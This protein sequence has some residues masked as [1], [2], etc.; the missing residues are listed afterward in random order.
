MLL[1]GTLFKLFD[2]HINRRR[3]R[4]IMGAARCLTGS[5]EKLQTNF[6]KTNVRKRG[7]NTNRWCS[8]KYH[9]NGYCDIPVCSNF[10]LFNSI[11]RWFG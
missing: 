11:V 4:I 3:Y 2:I 9:W 10:K 7:Q 5:S 8:A 6:F 1:R